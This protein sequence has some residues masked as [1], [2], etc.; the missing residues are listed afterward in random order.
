[1]LLGDICSIRS[2]LTFRDRLRD[3]REGGVLAVQQGDL[4]PAGEFNPDR[5]LRIDAPT[6]SS[7]RVHSD[8][9][10]I[11]SRGPFWSAWAP[12]D[13]GEPLVAVAPLFILHPTSDVHPAYLAWY[14]GRPA[15][16]RF[17]TTEAMGTGV[18]M[19]PR[20]VL[21]KLPIDVPPLATQRVIALSSSL[22]ARERALSLRLSDLRHD[23]LSTQLDRAALSPHLSESRSN[24]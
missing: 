7:H 22:A 1:M 3:V 20:A 16:Q 14:V 5:A 8:E 12:G 10:V 17:L 23:L 19:I 24:R 9:L 11:R 6:H 13:Y 4:T 15:A 2:G 18:K 21:E